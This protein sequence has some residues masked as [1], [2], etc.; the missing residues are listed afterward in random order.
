MEVDHQNNQ[1][2]DSLGQFVAAVI[3]RTDIPNACSHSIRYL[4]ETLLEQQFETD[5]RPE[6]DQIDYI[7]SKQ[8][9]ARSKYALSVW[10]DQ[11]NGVGL[12]SKY[13]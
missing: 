4:R 1:E 9:S 3:R 10:R 5:F 6:R 8:R 11:A 12:S 7:R 2:T 13:F